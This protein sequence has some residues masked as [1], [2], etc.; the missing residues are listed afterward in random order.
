MPP[1]KGRKSETINLNK[2]D[3]GFKSVEKNSG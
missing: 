3:D 2:S 1:K